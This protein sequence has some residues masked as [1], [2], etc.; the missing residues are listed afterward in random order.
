MRWVGGTIDFGDDDN[1]NDDDEL[2]SER[3]HLGSPLASELLK[4]PLLHYSSKL[5]SEHVEIR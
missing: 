5:A 2:R 1:D 4:R 3:V